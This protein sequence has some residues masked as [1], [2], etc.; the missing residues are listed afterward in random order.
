MSVD[1]GHKSITGLM[2]GR[3]KIQFLFLTFANN[4]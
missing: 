1:Y 3:G 2:K 4:T